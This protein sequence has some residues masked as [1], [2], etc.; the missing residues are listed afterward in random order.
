MAKKLKILRWLA[1]QVWSFTMNIVA[2]LTASALFVWKL[3]EWVKANQALTIAIISGATLILLIVGRIVASFWTVK[4]KSLWIVKA[5]MK[6]LP[7]PPHMAL[8]AEI[9]LSRAGIDV[10]SV[11]IGLIELGVRSLYLDN[12]NAKI[13][14]SGTLLTVR[15]L[16]HARED[17]QAIGVAAHGNRAIRV[18]VS[19]TNAEAESSGLVYCASD[20]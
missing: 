5:E 20:R 7:Q 14:A 9:E 17:F 15:P 1:A 10:S 8:R 3:P 4:A 11:Q 6:T 12:K 13:T 2:T 19:T 16:D 18:T